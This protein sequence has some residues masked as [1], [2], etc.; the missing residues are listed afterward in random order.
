MGEYHIG[1]VLLFQSGSGASVEVTIP[2]L[3]LVV[4]RMEE[5]KSGGSVPVVNSGGSV[6]E[7]ICSA[8]AAAWLGELVGGACAPLVPLSM[9]EELPPW[10]S[11]LSGEDTWTVPRQVKR[12]KFSA[13][14]GICVHVS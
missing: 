6:P 2:L 1:S 13:M 3:V 7:S 5:A 10:I 11:A 14:V 9:L 12:A 4:G 8:C